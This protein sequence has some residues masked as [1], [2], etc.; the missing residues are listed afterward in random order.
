MTEQYNTRQVNKA[1][2]R[3]KN[4]RGVDG[5]VRY[6][7]GRNNSK[8]GEASLTQM[9]HQLALQDIQEGEKNCS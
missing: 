9:P 8:S 3:Q 4:V 2:M 5:V 6:I 7:W 1:I